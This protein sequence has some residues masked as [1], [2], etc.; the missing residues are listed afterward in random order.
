MSREDS[1]SPSE[2]GHRKPNDGPFDLPR[3]GP[4][5]ARKAGAPWPTDRIANQSA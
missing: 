3:S 1:F 5:G 2:L 4:G